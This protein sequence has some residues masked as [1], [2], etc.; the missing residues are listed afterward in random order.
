[1]ATFCFLCGFN[2]HPQHSC[3][4]S[5]LVHCCGACLPSFL[6]YLALAL[7]A[8]ECRSPM[9][10]ASRR[11]RPLSSR[12]PRNRQ[13]LTSFPEGC[14]RFT[15]LLSRRRLTVTV[16]SPRCKPCV[17][18]LRCSS[19][20]EREADGIGDQRE[21]PLEASLLHHESQLPPCC[22]YAV[23]GDFKTTSDKYWYSWLCP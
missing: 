17:G 22:C 2:P 15:R 18:C 12:Y 9:R 11:L 6:A 13:G 4:W 20:Q 8:C 19:D 5:I 1:M 10:A 16:S 7:T 14:I 3:W 21:V 23:K